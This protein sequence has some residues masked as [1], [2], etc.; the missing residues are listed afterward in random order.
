VGVETEEGESK[1]RH[2]EAKTEKRSGEWA[3]RVRR[4]KENE[5]I[6]MEKGESKSKGREAKTEKREAVSEHGGWGE[7]GSRDGA[8]RE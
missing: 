1:K 4:E 3:W 2:R 8:G 6:E 5:Q 7:R